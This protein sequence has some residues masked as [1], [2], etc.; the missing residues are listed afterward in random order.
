MQLIYDLVVVGGGPGGIGAV[1]EA[2]TLGLQS[3]FLNLMFAST[4]QHGLRLQ[5][6]IYPIA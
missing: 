6:I 3:G 2:K 4:T 5:Q 1:V